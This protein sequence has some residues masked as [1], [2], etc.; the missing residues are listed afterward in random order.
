MDSAVLNWLKWDDIQGIVSFHGL[1][2][3]D[4]IADA[5]RP[6]LGHNKRRRYEYNEMPDNS[7]FNSQCAILIENGILD[8]HVTSSHRHRFAEEMFMHGAKNVRFHDH[9]DAKHGF[10]LAPGVISN[11]YHELSDRRS[12]ISMLLLFAELWANTDI[13]LKLLK[14]RSMHLEL[15][16]ECIGAFGKL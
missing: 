4:P 12:T 10:A 16:L 9:Y 1:L 6:W 5:S 7:N 2:Q 11:E 14:M 8:D 13:F 3:N 15:K